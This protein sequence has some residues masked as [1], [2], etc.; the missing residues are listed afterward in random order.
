V[1]HEIAGEVPEYLDPLDGTGWMQCIEAFCDPDSSL[2]SGQ[3]LRMSQF[4]PPTWSE[5][6]EQFEKLLEQ[7]G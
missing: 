5:H 3:L 2:R 6:F 1:F 7:V 4:T